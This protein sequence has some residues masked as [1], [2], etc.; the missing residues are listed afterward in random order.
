MADSSLVQIDRIAVSKIRFKL[1]NGHEI[2]FQFPP[3]ITQESN[4][5]TWEEKDLWAIE[6]LYIHKGSSGRKITMKWEYVATD[7]SW[8]AQRIGNMLRDLKSYFFEFK[9][10]LYPV[11]EVSFGTVIPIPTNFRIYDVSIA[12]SDELINNNGIHPLHTT[13]TVSLGLA[14]KVNESTTKESK[15]EVPPLGDA[16]PQWY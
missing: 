14:T 7:P 12:Y 1:N 2:R 11:A 13:V 5:S 10:E 3:K 6:P 9:R 8:D 15:L 16:I 4:S